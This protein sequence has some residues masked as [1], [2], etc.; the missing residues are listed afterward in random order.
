MPAL[1]YPLPVPG[2]PGCPAP[3]P[4]AAAAPI[5]PAQ[6]FLPRHLLPRQGSTG[7]WGPPSAPDPE[8]HPAWLGE[9]RQLRLG[10]ICAPTS[11]APRPVNPAPPQD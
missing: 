8:P 6:P 7:E 4:A 3:S 10:G 2:S 1:P 11:C 9:G 5:H